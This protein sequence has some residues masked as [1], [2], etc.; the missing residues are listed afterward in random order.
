MK[1]ALLTVYGNRGA[2]ATVARNI[3]HGLGEYGVQVD[4]LYLIGPPAEQFHG[5]PAGARPIRIGRHSRSC[6]LA[7]ARYLRRARPEALVSLLWT[8]NPAA[9]V[10]V[11]LA[12][13]R[14]PLV[15]NEASLLSYNAGVLYR[16][17]FNLRMLGSLARLLY[18]RASAVTGVSSAVIADLEH[19]IGLDP[20]RVPLHVIPN[21]VD[22]HQ[23]R[24]LS[25]IPDP[26]AVM[27]DGEPL[28]VHAGR[29]AREKNLPL[30]LAA[31]R[32]YLSGGGSGKLV[33]VG[34]GRDTAALHARA[35]ELGLCDHVVF[36]G[37][38]ANPFPQLAAATAFVLSSEQEGFGLAMAEAMALDVPVISTDCPGGP[39]E[40]LRGGRA[41]LLVR[42]HDP[43]ALA[44]AMRRVARDPAY[45]RSLAS[46]GARRV[47]DFAPS[48]VGRSWA[49]LLCRLAEHAPMSRSP[50]AEQC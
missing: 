19:G 39:R 37:Y 24:C 18:S 5:Y 9:V 20:R 21:A 1:I 3:A 26:A 48:A 47:Q 45:R 22:V 14:T 7:L 12:R 15:L 49:N 28:F 25:L 10:A 32:A 30:L 8:V 23:V 27:T 41:G 50:G 17:R 38:L 29:H 40:I 11:A 4:V 43:E 46:A 2:F 13:T 36:R 31:F 33:L 34:F 16:H 35:G 42:N 44:D 6:W